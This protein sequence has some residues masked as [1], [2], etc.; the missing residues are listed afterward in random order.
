ML[1]DRRGWKRHAD[2]PPNERANER[3]E[4]DEDLACGKG[5]CNHDFPF[6]R[7]E[8]ALIFSSKG[9]L[10]YCLCDGFPYLDA[11]AL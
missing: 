2:H 5:T 9:E 11:P 10:I 7:P 1:R 3:K 4:I 6:V 8:T